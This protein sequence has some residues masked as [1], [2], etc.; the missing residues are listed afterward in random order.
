[1]LNNMAVNFPTSLDDFTNPASGDQLNSPSHSQ[2]HKNINDAV[3]ALEAKVGVDSSAVTTSH[4]YKIAQLEASSHDAV[5]VTD[6]SEIDFTLDGQEITASI[7][8]GSIDE[9]KLDT[10]VNAS[11]DKADSAL[12]DL[13]DDT[14]PQLG[15]QLD[16]NGNAI[17]D[18]TNE[19]LKFEETA[20]AVN[21][22]TI[23]NN[24]TGNA[25]EIKATGDDTNIDLKLVGKGT[26][27][28][29]GRI[30]PRVSTET[31]SAT[32]TINT[33][34]VDA[35]SITALA[36]DITSFTTNLSGTPTNF[37]KLIIR[38]KDDGTARAI[39]W[40]ASFEAKGVALPTT[41]VISKVLT[42]G[43]IY[44]TVTSKWGCVASSQEE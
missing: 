15:G 26:G 41:T 1:L 27:G 7:K 12:Q 39:A 23:K 21:E 5:T 36:T 40:G 24:A 4:D 29:V 13:V 18:G 38:I 32:P 44:D 17:G 2:Q 31:S 6:S 20:S 35:H 14:T 42:V 22:I 11:L 25:P 34:N 16:V 8:S 37:Q 30:K 28:V 3:E 10:S 43:F 33:D 19:L 9:T